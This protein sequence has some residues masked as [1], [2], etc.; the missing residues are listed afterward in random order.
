LAVK[1]RNRYRSKSRNKLKL[2]SLIPWRKLKEASLLLLMVAGIVSLSAALAHSY[3]ALEEAPWPRLESIQITGLK[4]IERND[5][6]NAL[7]V[8]RNTNILTLRMSQLAKRVEA[9]PWV[10][11][12]VVRLDLPSRLVVEIVEREPLAVVYTD[13]F[14]L[15]DTEGKLFQQ[16]SPD[17]HAGLLLVTGMASSDFR[18]KDILAEEPLMALK[19]LLK[20]L[21]KAQGWLPL[22][23]ISQCHWQREIGFTLYTTQRAIPIQF[24]WDGFDAKLSR[25][26]RVVDALVSRD[27]WDLVTRIDMDYKNRVY[28]KG[29]FPIPKGI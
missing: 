17:S 4:R 13:A 10:R 1:K 11:S 5:V 9:L 24:G 16:V 14:Y 15:L 21:E 28:V 18:K 27:W 25:L 19:E 12:G 7:K 23:H 26:Q 22:S 6:L 29:N 8:P 20:A 3:Y 2:R